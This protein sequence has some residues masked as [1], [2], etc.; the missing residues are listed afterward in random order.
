VSS[1]K[2]NRRKSLT[3]KDLRSAPP[4]RRKS[5]MFNNLHVKH[6]LKNFQTNLFG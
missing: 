6:F 1:K 2:V 5:L 3:I 4:R